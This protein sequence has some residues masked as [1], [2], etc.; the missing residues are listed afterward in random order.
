MG[1]MKSKTKV[2]CVYRGRVMGLSYHNYC[3]VAKAIEAG[4]ELEMVREED[5]KHDANAI[6]LD[7]EGV[8]IGYVARSDNQVLSKLLDAGIDLKCFVSI[9]DRRADFDKR[10]LI[11]IFIAVGHG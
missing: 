3:L 1:V 4:D 9:H 6:R 10:M 5:N 2:E 11:Q 8:K 7:Y